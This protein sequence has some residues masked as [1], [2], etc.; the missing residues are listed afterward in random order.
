MK[1]I[2]Q[3]KNLFLISRKNIAAQHFN[4]L[5]YGNNFYKTSPMKWHTANITPLC[6]RT[7]QI[8]WPVFRGE[9]KY[10]PPEKNNVLE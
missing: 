7:R 1:I 3:C 2:S 6:K 5:Y 10:W 8:A 9:T 4:I